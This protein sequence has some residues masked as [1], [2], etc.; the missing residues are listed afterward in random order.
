MKPSQAL[1]TYLAIEMDKDKCY[2]PVY[3]DAS[4]EQH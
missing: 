1:K 3:Q 2:T 4:D